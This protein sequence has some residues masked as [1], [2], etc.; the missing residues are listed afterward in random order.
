MEWQFSMAG[1]ILMWHVPRLFSLFVDG[2]ESVFCNFRWHKVRLDV[3][4]FY[5]VISIA[6]CAIEL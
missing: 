6:I 3:K 5:Y 2:L 1:Q 4:M